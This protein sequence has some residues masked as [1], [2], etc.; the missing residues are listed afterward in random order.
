VAEEKGTES[1]DNGG[2]QSA[3]L[4]AKEHEIEQ[5]KKHLQDLT[6]LNQIYTTRIKELEKRLQTQLKLGLL[7]LGSVALLG[8]AL[9]IM[10]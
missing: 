5:L 8:L 4:E 3:A 2:G 1:S 6:R 10:A 9:L 7:A